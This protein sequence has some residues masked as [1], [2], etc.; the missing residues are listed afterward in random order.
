LSNACI[1]SELQTLLVEGY[2][3]LQLAVTAEVTSSNIN[4]DE[5]LNR[6]TTVFIQIQEKLG[7]AFGAETHVPTSE[8]LGFDIVKSIFEVGVKQRLDILN[9]ALTNPPDNT[10]FC[11][12]LHSQSEVFIGLAESLNL[13]GLEKLARTIMAV[14]DANP[15]KVR[16]IAKIAFTDLKAAQIAV[17]GGDRTSGG[18]ASLELQ[19][20]VNTTNDDLFPVITTS[21]LATI[22]KSESYLGSIHQSFADT[23]FNNTTEFYHF[24]TTLSNG[25]NQPLK[26]VHAKVYLKTIRYIFGWFNQYR[27]IPES[28]LNL[29]LLI[30]SSSQ[31]YPVNYLEHWLEQFLYFIEKVGD[32]KSLCLHRR[33]VIL[34]I[35]L[36]IAKFQYTV[37]QNNSAIPIIKKLRQQ[38]RELG[39]EYKNYPPVTEAEKNWLDHPKLQDLLVIKEIVPSSLLEENNSLLESIWGGESILEPDNI[40]AM[41]II[42]TKEIMS[43][44]ITPSP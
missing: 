30:P 35:I 4:A 41:P 2:E 11:E 10:E 23:F 34:I 5:L 19:A 17:L 20:L 39:K 29:S 13:P 16:E 1:D 22:P 38:I 36:A 27:E 6:A 43:H 8:E 25:N 26:P 15:Q 18:S 7:D 3:C 44:L 31:K 9:Q 12:L 21:S 37:E 33:G 14:L 24:L 32:S 28:E 42:E 40:L